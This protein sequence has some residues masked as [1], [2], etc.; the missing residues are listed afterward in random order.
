M[1]TIVLEWGVLDNL[2]GI[3]V[4]YCPLL[5]T[6]ISDT[7]PEIRFLAGIR[8]KVLEVPAIVELVEK[9]ISVHLK[10]VS[11]LAIRIICCISCNT[12]CTLA[13]YVHMLYISY[14]IYT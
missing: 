2:F 13:I 6:F 12:L 1:I 8:L 7:F 11:T 9:L 4:C 5:Q 3:Y 10:T 14:I